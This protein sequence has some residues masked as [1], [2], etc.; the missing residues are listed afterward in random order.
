MFEFIDPDARV[1]FTSPRFEGVTFHLRP[2]PS[3]KWIALRNASILEVE[4][5]R[6]RAVS[7]LV[8]EKADPSSM[9][10]S[11]TLESLRANLDPASSEELSR[12]NAEIVRWGVDSVEG[13][14]FRGA[15][16]ELA[17]EPVEHEGVRLQVL[18][19]EAVRVLSLQRGLILELSNRLWA[20]NDLGTVEKKS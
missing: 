1:P 6:R 17:K 13:A 9:V 18:T 19:Y 16:L 12:L 4:R 3:G 20:L 7:E 14:T 8:A 2:I 11:L 15:P 5:A 10:G